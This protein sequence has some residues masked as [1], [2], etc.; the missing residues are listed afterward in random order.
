MDKSVVTAEKKMKDETHV[1]RGADI[2]KYLWDNKDYLRHNYVSP[3]QRR[4]DERKSSRQT[5]DF[6]RHI[7]PINGIRE[8]V[9]CLHC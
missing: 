5:I 6:D 7:Y 3:T 4:N 1:F 2:E 8:N 9:F